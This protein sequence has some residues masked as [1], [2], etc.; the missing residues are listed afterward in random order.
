MFAA[1]MLLAWTAFGQENAEVSPPPPPD[2]VCPNPSY[3]DTTIFGRTVGQV[4]A[5]YAACQWSAVRDVKLVVTQYSPAVG[6]YRDD[7]SWWMGIPGLPASITTTHE[8]KCACWTSVEAV[9]F[10]FLLGDDGATAL[11]AVEKDF[12][13][14]GGAVKTFE[15]LKTE[16]AKRAGFAPAIS[17]GEFM[18]APGEFYRA[19][20]ARWNGKTQDM[21][22]VLNDFLFGLGHVR[23]MV[24]HKGEW[25]KYRARLAAVRK[26][27]EDRARAAGEGAAGEL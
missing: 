24:V 26:A 13:T 18:L 15:A 22:L 27:E 17:T 16:T 10:V 14:S 25:A 8:V 1:L 7:L 4:E 20:V 5:E 6:W 9:R 11:M 19:A 21:M 12:Q 3:P 2:P 23:T